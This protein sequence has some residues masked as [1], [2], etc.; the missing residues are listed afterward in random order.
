MQYETLP[1]GLNKKEADITPKVMEWFR[2][3]Y[4]WTAAIEIKVNKNKLKDHQYA[5]LNEV[6]SGL[7]SFKIPD[8]GRRNPFDFVILRDAKALVVI[9]NTEE[10]KCTAHYVGSVSSS[11]NVPVYGRKYA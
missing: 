10:R 9:C 1:K 6:A 7:F 2:E 3:N 4:P 5:S 11:F 8:S